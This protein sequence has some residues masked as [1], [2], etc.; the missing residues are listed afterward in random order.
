[1]ENGSIY[2]KLKQNRLMYS[3]LLFLCTATFTSGCAKRYSTVSR[4]LRE[5]PSCCTSLS[6]I[7]TE[8]IKIGESLTFGL[9]N[10]SPVYGFETGKS[11]FRAFALPD[12]ATPYEVT[13]DSYP[14]G[15]YLKNAYVF[16]PRIITLDRNRSIIRSSGP[17]T[18]STGRSGLVEAL[19]RAEGLEQKLSGSM[20]F[21]DNSLGERYLVIHTTDALLKERTS[22]PVSSDNSIWTMGAANTIKEEVD[23]PHAAAGKISISVKPL[24][25]KD[26]TATLPIKPAIN[27]SV[28]VQNSKSDLA[29]PAPSNATPNKTITAKT[30]E[31]EV[32]PT[33]ANYSVP[34]PVFVTTRHMN[35]TEF[36]VLELGKSDS[37]TAQQ[38][39]ARAGVTMGTERASDTKLQIGS[40]LVQPKRLYLPSTTPHQLYFDENDRLVLFVDSTPTSLPGNSMEF[41][42][43][44]PGAW[45]SGRN[46]SFYKLQ[47]SLSRCVALIASFRTVDDSLGS[48][49]FAYMCATKK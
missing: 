4:E 41:L 29:Q 23:V 1:M 38:H 43:Q 37:T 19:Q 44:F 2:F 33:K 10:G 6:Q 47:T 7:P 39:F 11:Y 40:I 5:S 14:V 45:E 21:E 46:Q 12:T 17:E 16:A 27:T 8:Q 32:P 31:L 42:Q 34:N 28:P 20:T 13:V 9:G 15:G 35:G 22:V 18:F 30:K 49:S 3:L 26:V 36:G 48:V 24:R 25:K